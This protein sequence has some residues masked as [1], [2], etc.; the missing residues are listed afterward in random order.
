MSAP[1]DSTQAMASSATLM[2][3]AAML[4]K[5]FQRGK[6]WSRFCALKRGLWERKSP[7]VVALSLDQWP[8][9]KPRASTP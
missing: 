6:V 4:R 1:R 3:F 8:L 5:E 9:I 2:P 7:G